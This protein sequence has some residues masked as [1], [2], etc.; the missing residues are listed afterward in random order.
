MRRDEGVFREGLYYLEMKVVQLSRTMLWSIFRY[1]LADGRTA[2]PTSQLSTWTSTS[3]DLLK[4][5]GRMFHSLLI[6]A[7]NST[8]LLSWLGVQNDLLNIGIKYD[9]IN[10]CN[11][12]CFSQSL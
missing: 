5:R 9:M 11:F 12:H 3:A 10:G 8:R 2:Q 7:G 4:I 6:D 1:T